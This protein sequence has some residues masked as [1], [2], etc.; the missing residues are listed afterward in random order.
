MNSQYVRNFLCWAIESIALTTLI[1][2][3]SPIVKEPSP[4]TST[5]TKINHGEMNHDKISSRMNHSMDLGPADADYDLRFIDAMIPHHEGAL[6]MA[7]DAQRKSK[8]PEIQELANSIISAQTKEIVQMKQWRKTWYPTAPST[9]MAW[10]TEMRHTMVMRP[11]QIR[12]M[13]M[14]VDLAAS[15]AEYDLRFIKAMIP[16]HEAAVVMAKD[17]A[18]KTQRSDLKKV[19]KDILTFQQ[20]E[21]DQMEKWQKDWGV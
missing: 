5:T 14:D 1:S 4:V 6:I 21:I 20:A 18:L 16:H 11:E 7:K 3:C 15:D 19:A 2:A 9:P 17:L 8:R 12:A 10:H 13:R